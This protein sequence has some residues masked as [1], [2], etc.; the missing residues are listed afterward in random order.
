MRKSLKFDS[1]LIIS[2]NADSNDILLIERI[3]S[4]LYKVD[5]NVSIMQLLIG[6]ICLFI[7]KLLFIL[8]IYK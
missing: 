7:Y 3:N 2:K 1:F 8:V 4:F 5:C 6:F